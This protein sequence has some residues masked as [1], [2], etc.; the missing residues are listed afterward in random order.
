M[1]MSTRTL[2]ALL[3]AGAM[4]SVA[5][6]GDDDSNN[7]PGLPSTGTP[8][9]G[10]GL[11][12]VASNPDGGTSTPPVG[13]NADGGSSTPPAMVATC[14]A[15]TTDK[16]MFCELSGS[17]E[18]PITGTVQLEPV[19]GKIGYRLNG[20]VFVG[21]DVGGC[22]P[23]AA[24]KKVG[25]LVIKPGTVIMG[26][27]E[28]SFLL[29][30]RGSTIEA[31]GEPNNP[32]VFTR[33]VVK[34][35]MAGRPGM[36]GGLILNGRASSNKGCD[37]EG[38][39]GTGKYGGD[40]DADNS[41]TLQYVHLEWT[42]G[43]I[44]DT[45]ELNGVAFQGV[46]S[47][48]KVDHVHVHGSDDDAFEWFGGTVNAKHLVATATGDDGLDW[49]DGY[50]GKIQFA[51]VQ[52]WAYQ[53]SPHPHGIEADNND[54]KFDSTPVATPTLSNITVL[55]G[56][57]PA[58]KGAHIRRGTKPTIYS[59]VFA[60]FGTCLHVQDTPVTAPTFMNSRISCAVNYQAGADGPLTQAAFE[61][62][63]G[64][65]MVIAPG[66]QLVSDGASKTPNFAPQAG[67]PLL[68]GGAIPANDPWFE[69]AD[70]IGAIGAT[71]WTK[72][73]TWVQL[74]SF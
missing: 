17:K 22:G 18:A 9:G 43:K 31:V 64:N 2:S 14:P 55:G 21:E 40:N 33:D 56:M 36:W 32:I 72:Q 20:G 24:D 46:G 50:R 10:A 44:S 45:Q 19:A 74:P 4:S 60:N 58:N 5:A 57:V 25:K 27:T 23:A 29:I 42:G 1:K 39:A 13:G 6:C 54:P 34:A 49:T 51:V 59:A 35:G 26:N 62:A 52:Q 69:A 66:T 12:P 47:G 65:N 30:N 68:T 37:V 41:G 70:Y 7:G 38:E 53:S 11:P 8:D 73:G 48:T 71:D 16:G 67:S 63:T 3:L 28:L 61:S 15:G